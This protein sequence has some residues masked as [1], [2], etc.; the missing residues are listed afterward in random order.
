MLIG[1]QEVVDTHL[2]SDAQQAEVKL[3]K[4]PVLGRSIVPKFQVFV[5]AQVK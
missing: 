4:Q 2:P 5:L 3:L 1:K